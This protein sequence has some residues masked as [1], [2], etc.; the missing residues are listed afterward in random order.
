VPSGGDRGA[1]CL[2]PIDVGNAPWETTKAG[3]VSGNKGRNPRNK[4]KKRL[5]SPPNLKKEKR[6]QDTYYL[7]GHD[8][9]GACKIHGRLP[10]AP[11]RRSLVDM[12]GTWNV[13]LEGRHTAYKVTKSP[14]GGEPTV[15]MGTSGRQLPALFIGPWFRCADATKVR[16][17]PSL[18]LRGRVMEHRSTCS[19]SFTSWNKCCR[20][21]A[22]TK[23]SPTCDPC[24]L[25][26]TNR[27]A[28]RCSTDGP[29]STFADRRRL[30]RRGPAP[31]PRVSGPVQDP[32]QSQGGCVGAAP[33]L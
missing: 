26:G 13:L 2:E 7:C 14:S 29:E 8:P 28:P 17:P 12:E 32:A 11:L 15:E 1:D 10:I 25:R 30:Y 6:R 18:K 21:L 5:A 23:L 3:Q 16:W 9:S 24:V 19:P 27:A 33:H 31:K 4:T 22:M 20:L